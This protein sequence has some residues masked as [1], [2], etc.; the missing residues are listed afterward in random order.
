M[1]ASLGAR[2]LLAV[3][4]G[5]VRSVIVSM[6]TPRPPRQCL[7]AVERSRLL[8]PFPRP[9][10]A[11]G[12]ACTPRV[13]VLV[14]IPTSGRPPRSRRFLIPI[15]GP[16]RG[17]AMRT[18]A[19][20]TV[21]VNGDGLDA[22]SGGAIEETPPPVLTLARTEASHGV[23]I[24]PAQTD[25]TTETGVPLVPPPDGEVVLVNVGALPVVADAIQPSGDETT[26]LRPRS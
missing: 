14:P 24:E 12:L 20:G 9:E 5:G 2:L 4:E 22:T 21:L 1:L 11:E 7:V 23:S 3:Q 6:A 15:V 16:P 13:R 18:T 10:E 25:H 8:L 17:L 19:H 26:R